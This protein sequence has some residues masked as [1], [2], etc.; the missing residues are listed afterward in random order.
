MRRP[1]L[2]KSSFSESGEVERKWRWGMT[3]LLQT[4]GIVAACMAIIGLGLAFLGFG[5]A[6]VRMAFED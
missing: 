3:T 6:V 5:I 4:C 2:F 1:C